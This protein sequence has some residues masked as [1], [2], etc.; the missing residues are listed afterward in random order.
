MWSEGHRSLARLY[1]TLDSMGKL[2]QMH[3]EI[4]KAIHDKG[5]PLVANDPTDTA[6]TERIQS[7]FVKKFGISEDDFRKAYHSFAVDTALQKADQLMERYRI[8]A[9]PTFVINGKYVA[10]VHTA[11]GPERLISLVGDLAALEHKR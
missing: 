4:F 2:D 10:D 5:N 3:G 11:D 1:Y 9:V 8:D 6:E 7:L